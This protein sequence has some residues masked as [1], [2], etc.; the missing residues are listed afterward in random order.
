LP[1]DV[2]ENT[3]KNNKYSDMKKIE[4]DHQIATTTTSK[5]LKN[6][7]KMGLGESEKSTK[8]ESKKNLFSK[9][10]TLIW[11]IICVL[12]IMLLDWHIYFYICE[13]YLNP[14]LSE[15]LFEALYQKILR[16]LLSQE[17]DTRR[18]ATNNSTL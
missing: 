7:E 4:K 13:N 3:D 15:I 1:D 11:Q 14:Y 12:K 16:I 5:R 17:S 8:W 6:R 18:L 9:V 10:H 2:R